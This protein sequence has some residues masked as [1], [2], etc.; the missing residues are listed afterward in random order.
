MAVGKGKSRFWILSFFGGRG[1]CDGVVL[2]G[3][4]TAMIHVGLGSYHSLTRLLRDR[5]MPVLTSMLDA[6]DADFS[7]HVCVQLQP[8]VLRMKFM[9][10]LLLP[11]HFLWC[12]PSVFRQVLSKYSISFYF[13]PFSFQ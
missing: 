9:S 11:F 13:D 8:R 12:L 10:C 7:L 1:L 3:S 2:I 6:G 5:L 4:C